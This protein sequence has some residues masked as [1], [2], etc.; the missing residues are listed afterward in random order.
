MASS[1]SSR[2]KGPWPLLVALLVVVGGVGAWLWRSTRETGASDVPLWTVARG[3]LRIS[4][5]EGGSL[6]SLRSTTVASEVE[7]ETKIVDVVAEGT[8]LTEDDVAKGRVIVELDKSSLEEK[9]RRQVITISGADADLAR[10]KEALKIQQNQNE[11][12]LR[13]AALD[14]QFARIDLRKYV[15]EAVAGRLEEHAGDIASLDLRALA[16]AED[17]GGEALQERRKRESDIALAKEELARARDKLKWT[18]ELLAKGFV[19]QD[20]QVADRLAL[21]RNDV[22]LEQADTA[23]SLFTAYEFPKQVQR[24]V[25]DLR[26]AKEA[27]TRTKRRADSELASALSDVKGKEEKLTLETAELER[28]DRQVAA[29]TI[30]ATN[31]GLVV[32]ASSEDRGNWM[33]DEKPIQPGASIRQRQPILSIPDPKG[34]GVRV[35]VHESA[36]DRVKRG[37]TASIVVDAFPDRPMRGRVERISTMPNQ[38]NRWQNPDLKLYATDVA[39]EDAP[40]TLR[41]GMS[42][43]VEILV[44]ELASAVYV[45]VQAVTFVAGKTTVYVREGGDEVARPV[46]LGLSSDRYVEVVEGLSEGEKVM[47]APP[48]DRHPAGGGKEGAA[49]SGD[50]PAPGAGAAPAG[51]GDRPAGSPG[52][53]G[54]GGRGSRGNGGGAP[55]ASPSAPTGDAAA[56]SS[57]PGAPAMAPGDAP[58]RPGS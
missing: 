25:S 51:G 2:R 17:V 40:N 22:A 21:K 9:R 1:S 5:T 16:S 49:P 3:P 39:L 44:E 58:A 35:N 15:G 34:L 27:E 11:S 23:L 52:G 4:V 8:F 20:E 41:P 50:R 18:E 56:G 31:P 10:A 32:Y 24:L 38:A 14:V 46:R 47:L 57:A 30:R 29:C 42:A 26:E 45:P 7:G 48:K 19:S 55:G 53:R 54:R 43:R 28:I 33:G 36:L 12:D 13:K 6:Q 37:Q